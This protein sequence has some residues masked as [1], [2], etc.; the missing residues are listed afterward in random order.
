MDYE[1]FASIIIPTKKIDGF[2]DEAVS[3]ILRLDYKNYEIIIL[4]DVAPQRIYPRTKI[5]VTGPI[6]PAE[7]RDLALE[8]SNGEILAF[9]DDDAY[10]REDWLRQ[11]VKHF[12]DPEVAAVG[13]P[14]V[15]PE[16]DGLLRKVS[17]AILSSRICSGNY[18]YRYVPRGI[19]DVDDFPSVNLLIRKD[20]F[21][22]V[23]G[24]DTGYWPGEDTKICLDITKKLGKRI[25]YDPAVLVWHHRRPVF[26]PHLRQIARYALHRGYFVKAFPET[27]RRLGYFI[28]TLFVF[29]L[30]AGVLLSLV[31]NTIR[32]A[33]LGAVA[34]YTGALG[35]AGLLAA[36][37]N[38]DP[39]IG[40][41]VIP[42]IFLTHVT[43]GVYFLKGLMVKDLCR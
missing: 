38:R 41:L 33:Y 10:P 42:G 18:T 22:A 2:V 26:V 13:G 6:G 28:P 39:L 19:Q 16:S 30:V 43:Y 32:P 23:G 37:S 27:S 14:A 25:I 5:I 35:L 31:S 24:F 3:H 8:H 29:G 15:T 11:A 17:G 9:I 12:N 7:K 20:I 36:W 4:P 21:E 34:F 40:V 1:P